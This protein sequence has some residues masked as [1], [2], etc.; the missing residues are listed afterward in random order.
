MRLILNTGDALGGAEDLERNCRRHR[1]WREIIDAEFAGLTVKSILGNHEY[2]WLPEDPAIPG[3]LNDLLAALEMP[4]R[5]YQFDEAGWRFIAIDS[6]RL[7]R[8][9]E[10][11]IAWLENLLAQTPAGMP[12]AISMSLTSWS[13]L[14]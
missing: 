8:G 4:G 13:R 11:Q 2:D 6:T 9:D 3:G 5:Y 14:T 12:V 1:L 7:D 10:A